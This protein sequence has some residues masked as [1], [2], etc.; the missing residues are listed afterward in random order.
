[1]KQALEVH[2]PHSPRNKLLRV[3]APGARPGDSRNPYQSNGPARSV[4]DMGG[5]VP[6]MGESAQDQITSQSEELREL[7]D[8][9][10]ATRTEANRRFRANGAALAL[11][12]EAL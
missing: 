8:Q 5:S 2:A 12:G 11:H 4:P 7:R 6:D 10:A 1:M 3:A 9:E